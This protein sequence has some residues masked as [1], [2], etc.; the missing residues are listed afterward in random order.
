VSQS[1]GLE[2]TPTVHGLHGDRVFWTLQGT[3]PQPKQLQSILET[4]LATP[5]R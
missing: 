5:N 1:L 3:L 2:G 4:W